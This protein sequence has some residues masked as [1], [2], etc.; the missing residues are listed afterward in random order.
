[1]NKKKSLYE[2]PTTDILVVRF[3]G[4]VCTSPGSG[5]N[6]SGGAGNVMNEEVIEQLSL[7]EFCQDWDVRVLHCRCWK[8]DLVDDIGPC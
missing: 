7:V 4:M 2:A 3:E 6:R 5:Y 1:M 8:V